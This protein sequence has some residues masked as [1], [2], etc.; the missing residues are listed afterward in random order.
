MPGWVQAARKLAAEISAYAAENWPRLDEAPNLAADL[1]RLAQQVE[2]LVSGDKSSPLSE[3]EA[4]SRLGKTRQLAVEYRR[5]AVRVEN[6]RQRLEEIQQSETRAKATLEELQKNL[7]QIRLVAS[8]NTF[9]AGAAMPEMDLLVRSAQEISGELDKR[10]RR[11][12]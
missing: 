8:S 11:Q 2:L 6:I 9:L 10:Q 3:L 7:G 12:C 5:L 4:F 1:D